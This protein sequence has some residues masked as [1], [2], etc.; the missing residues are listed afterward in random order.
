MTVFFYLLSK[1]GINSVG[2]V[3]VTVTDLLVAKDNLNVRISLPKH[4]QPIRGRSRKMLYYN[5]KGSEKL[6]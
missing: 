6:T 4:Y 3:V 5:N 2:F 1:H